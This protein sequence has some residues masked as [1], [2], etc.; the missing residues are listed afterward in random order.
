[1]RK[2]SSETRPKRIS[3]WEKVDFHLQLGPYLW[4]NGIDLDT[5]PWDSHLNTL[6]QLALT[7]RNHFKVYNAY[8]N[9]RGGNFFACA[10]NNGDIFA[11]LSRSLKI[12]AF[13]IID[14]GLLH[15]LS[16]SCF[17]AKW[18]YW[19]DL[20]WISLCGASSQHPDG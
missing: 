16:I 18:L 17:V 10:K 15:F 2:R 20:K 5:C 7:C 1:M 8:V 9:L 19:K 14:S 4:A 12:A 11:H 13:S 6:F 3:I